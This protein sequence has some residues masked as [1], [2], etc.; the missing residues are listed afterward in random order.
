MVYAAAVS[1]WLGLA[2]GVQPEPLPAILLADTSRTPLVTVSWRDESGAWV[3]LEGERGYTSPAGTE[4]LG[5]NVSAY[6]A[7]GGTRLDRGA[8]HPRGAVIRVG[9]YKTDARRAF[10]EGIAD[11]GSITLRLTGVAM[12]RPVKPW[13]ASIVMH[14]K[15]TPDELAA[16]GLGASS[17]VLF[18]TTSATDTLNGKIT[19]ETGQLGLLDG[20]HEGVSVALTGEA[21]GTVAL[22]ATF[23]YALLRHMSDPWL[24]TAPGTFLEPTHFHFEFEVLPPEVADAIGDPRR[25]ARPFPEGPFQPDE[26]AVGPSVPPAGG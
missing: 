20:R 12:N 4:W 21:D 2:G 25:R 26:P 7:L 3:K 13:P 14:I 17:A 9:V 5:K 8:A 24:R 22:S 15:Y 19:P 10:F 11:G 1:F 18:Y 23:P 16:C 6:V